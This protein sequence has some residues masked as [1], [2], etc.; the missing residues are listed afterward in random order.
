MTPSQGQF[1]VFG[2]GQSVMLNWQSMERIV[3]E[4]K[5]KWPIDVRFG[6]PVCGKLF[7]H[8]RFFEEFLESASDL[9][10]IFSLRDVRQ[11]MA[12]L[13][14]LKERARQTIAPHLAGVRGA[15]GDAAPINLLVCFSTEAPCEF[16][17][18]GLGGGSQIVSP[19]TSKDYLA[20]KVANQLWRRL[21]ALSD[22]PRPSAGEINSI[23]YLLGRMGG[24]APEGFQNRLARE[25]YPVTG[26]VSLFAAGRVLSNADHGR[27][28][29]STLQ[30]KEELGQALNNNWLRMLVYVLYQR[31]DVLR[32]VPR[33][34]V[35]AA[36]K[37]ALDALEQQVQRGNVRILFLNSLRALALLLRIRRHAHAR[38]FLCRDRCPPDEVRLA[39]RFA[40]LLREANSLR[41]RPVA[42]TLV[43]RTAE[44]LE[45]A[46]L[47]DE[48]PP[49]APPDEEEETEGRSDD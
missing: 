48:M 49:I 38:D 23:I 6:W 37:L 29:F 15:S 47:T 32:E 39:R 24:Y 35:L 20:R 2:S 7:A 8:R 11:R 44:W 36:T 5:Q 26:G 30:E 13:N 22:E 28:L 12:R 41:L 21:K 33:E 9:D 19:L 34:H 31:S 1:E 42:K 40:R 46:A 14:L 3:R 45:F 25:I 17:E 43:E 27:R 16:M 4:P 10:S 18:A